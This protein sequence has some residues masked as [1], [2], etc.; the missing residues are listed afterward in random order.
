MAYTYRADVT[1]VVDVEVKAGSYTEAETLLKEHL[2]VH[3][4]AVGTIDVLSLD[5]LELQSIESDDDPE[6]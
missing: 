6:N 2:D 5:G 3:N 4:G 1:M